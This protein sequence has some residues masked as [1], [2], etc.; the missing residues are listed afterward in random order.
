VADGRRKGDAPMSDVVNVPAGAMDRSGVPRDSNIELLRIVCIIGITMYHFADHGGFVFDQTPLL[1]NELFIQTISIFGK[2]GVNCFILISGYYLVSTKGIAVQKIL[3]IWGEML[4]YS[5]GISIVLWAAGVGTVTPEMIV[6]SLLPVL[7]DT[8]WFASCY[9]IM[10]ILAP[11]LNRMV[12]S[13]DRRMHMELI[14]VLLLLWSVVFTVTKWAVEGGNLSWFITLYLV[15]AY[16]RLYGGRIA[17]SMALNIVI[18]IVS[19]AVMELS[20]IALDLTVSGGAKLPY[21]DR[22]FY[23]GMRSLP[24]FALSLSVFNIFR[25]IRMEHHP[26]LNALALTTFGVYLIQEHPLMKDYLWQGLFR[27]FEYSHSDMLVLH[28]LMAVS[29]TYAICAAIDAI[30]IRTAEKAFMAAFR[31]TKLSKMVW[32]TE[33]Q[34]KGNDVI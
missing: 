24:Q 15:A 1:I 22:V 27:N 9:F 26:C 13:I 5:L 21:C 17:D 7:T 8:W 19:I 25:N 16:L 14:A 29:I 33:Q 6:I 18:A 28:M 31:R 34:S 11:F 2:M 23:V 3:K 32:G 12:H 20:F 30:R 10:L 4:F